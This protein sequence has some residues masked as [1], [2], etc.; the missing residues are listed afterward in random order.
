M[1]PTR[2]Q[3]IS[4]SGLSGQKPLGTTC[5]HHLLVIYIVTVPVPMREQSMKHIY[6]H[7]QNTVSYSTQD[8]F[9]PLPDLI[10]CTVMTMYTVCSP[11]TP[12]Q[13]S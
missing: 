9:Q 6:Y 11:I 2:S 5:S 4:G 13:D 10:S 7:F 12:T 1:Y 3:W 8:L